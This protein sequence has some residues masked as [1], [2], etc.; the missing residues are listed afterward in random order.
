[1]VGRSDATIMI[2]LR[3]MEWLVLVIVS[4]D[5]SRLPGWDLSDEDCRW[6]TIPRDEAQNRS[7]WCDCSTDYP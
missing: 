7:Q 2:W 3:G 5:A 1:M 6:L 4:V